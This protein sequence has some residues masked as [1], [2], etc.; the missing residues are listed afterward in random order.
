MQNKLGVETGN[1]DEKSKLRMKEERAKIKEF[2][3][4]LENELIYGYHSKGNISVDEI[5]GDNSKKVKEH[6][7]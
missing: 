6:Q 1:M 3:E 5:F 4:N 2:L 7:F